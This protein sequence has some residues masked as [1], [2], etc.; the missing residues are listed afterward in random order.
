MIG[1]FYTLICLIALTGGIAT[2]ISLGRA[3]AAERAA[4]KRNAAKEALMFVLWA[5]GLVGGVGIMLHRSWGLYVLELFCYA[6]VVMICMSIYGRYQDI[7]RRAADEHINWLA[8][9]AGLAIVG[10]P[11][12]VIAYLTIAVLRSESFRA[13]FIP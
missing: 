10:V 9:G 1:G 12:M 11:I 13:A 5:V 8:A 2:L 3:G 4:V 6:L 7:K